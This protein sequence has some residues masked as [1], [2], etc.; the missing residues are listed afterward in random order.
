[1]ADDL[2]AIIVFATIKEKAEWDGTEERHLIVQHI[3][4][5]HELSWTDRL[6]TT[7]AQVVAMRKP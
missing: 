2:T 3:F 1:M 7:F 4:F 5:P 6:K